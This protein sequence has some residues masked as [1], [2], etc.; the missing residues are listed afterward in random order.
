[1]SAF[2]Q[3]HISVK[4]GKVNVLR[5]HDAEP[6]VEANKEAQKDDR[7]GW[8]KTKA[9]RKIGTIPPVLFE[10]F[11]QTPFPRGMLF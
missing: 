9:L 2:P 8:G 5:T 6:I 7:R 10:R 1:M 4:D 11:L 3:T